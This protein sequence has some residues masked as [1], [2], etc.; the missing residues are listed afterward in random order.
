MDG[1]EFAEPDCP[2]F[3]S[4][5]I[6]DVRYYIWFQQILVRIYLVLSVTK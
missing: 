3:L 6:T 2:R 4:I 5:G 1:L